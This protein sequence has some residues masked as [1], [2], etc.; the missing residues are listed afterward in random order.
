[1]KDFIKRVY[2][3]SPKIISTILLLGLL[4]YIILV[5]IMIILV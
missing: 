1:M 5:V 3:D 2:N 4:I